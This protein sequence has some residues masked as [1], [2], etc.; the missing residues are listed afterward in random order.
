[1]QLFY[2]KFY[3]NR[4]KITIII[5]ESGNTAKVKHRE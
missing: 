2:E 1:M 5:R 4:K 3:D